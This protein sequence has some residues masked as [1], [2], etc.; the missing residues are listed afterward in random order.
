MFMA[1]VA[2][3]VSAIPEGLPAIMT[4]TLAIGV[5]R[6]PTRHA[7]IRYLP[8]VETLGSTTVICLDKTGTLTRNEMTVTAVETPEGRFRVSGVGYAPL[9]GSV[10]EAKARTLASE[11]L[12]VLALGAK[13]MTAKRKELALQDVD[14]T[15]SLLGLVGMLGL[16]REEAIA[17]VE[18][19]RTA[20]IRVTMITGDH[21]ETALA[22]A[23]QLGIGDGRA[24]AGADLDR[25]DDAAFS[26][27]AAQVDVFARVTP[28]PKL[29]L[30]RALHQQGD[31]VAM[32]GDGVNDAPALKQADIG[33]AMGVT[34]TEV[35]KEAADMVLVDEWRRVSDTDHRHCYRVL[36]PVLPLHILWINLVTTI[37]LAVTLA[38]EP[39]E[40]N[41]IAQPPRRPDV[42][43]L[44]AVLVWR[45]AFVSMLMAAVLVLQAVFTY[46]PMMHLFFHTAPLDEGMWV[47][48]VA[49]SMSLL[50][51]VE[52]ERAI[53]RR[54]ASRMSGQ[55]R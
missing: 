29:R 21:V 47:R 41:T 3:A 9:D 39:V 15:F 13:L 22:L 14:A 53:M 23:R 33:I 51:V 32:T 43:L 54:L 42:P 35:A 10:W 38:F 40:A 48:I 30:V 11:G 6:I 18:Q 24:V 31:V 8:A 5:K 2:L 12:R 25:M 19:C 45:I 44:D 52:A 34:G 28:A 1:A 26:S 20:G 17:A 16:P 4:I 49:V 46:W 36:L 37:A 55:A 7:I 50:L 27:M